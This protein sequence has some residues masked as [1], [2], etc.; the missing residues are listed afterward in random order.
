M[1][2]L[3]VCEK[4]R[5]GYKVVLSKKTNVRV[6]TKYTS[7]IYTHPSQVKPKDQLEFIG[8]VG[9]TEEERSLWESYLCEV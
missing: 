6:A 2:E 9:A 3:V 5:Q 1:L 7:S 4:I 8:W